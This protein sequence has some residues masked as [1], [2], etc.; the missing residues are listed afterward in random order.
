MTVLVSGL[1][2][3][4][5]VLKLVTCRKWTEH[6]ICYEELVEWYMNRT[7]VQKQI[8]WKGNSPECLGPETEWRVEVQ[9]NQRRLVEETWKINIYI[10]ESYLI[11]PVSQFCLKIF[12]LYWNPTECEWLI[13]IIK[14]II[15]LFVIRNIV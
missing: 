7:Y 2:W 3:L 15:L 10:P 9:Q 12:S 5:F 14:I 13:F 11:K 1:C 6:H 8:R 4:E